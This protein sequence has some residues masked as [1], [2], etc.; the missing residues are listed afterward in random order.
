[1]MRCARGML[2][3]PLMVDGQESPIV[4]VALRRS[5]ELWLSVRGL[6]VEKVVRKR[7]DDGGTLWK[8]C[9]LENYG[10]GQQV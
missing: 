8:T 3:Q 10:L 7:K 6:G 5:D 4:K 2:A 9:L 1:M